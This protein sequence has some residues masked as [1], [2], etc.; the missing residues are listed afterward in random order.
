M[1][2][3][4]VT[5]QTKILKEL[6]TV[7]TCSNKHVPLSSPYSDTSN[8][9]FGSNLI[10]HSPKHNSRAVPKALSLSPAV[11]PKGACRN[12]AAHSV[13]ITALPSLGYCVHNKE[14]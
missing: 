7:K 2:V 13:L 6:L 8:S 14:A 12:K 11:S 3:I 1:L 4:L 5:K 9:L 10:H